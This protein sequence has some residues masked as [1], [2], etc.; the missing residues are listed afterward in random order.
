MSERV[1]CAAGW[2]ASSPRW[3]SSRLCVPARFR[4]SVIGKDGFVCEDK[5]DALSAALSASAERATG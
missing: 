3:T 4:L 2:P 1:R 5:R